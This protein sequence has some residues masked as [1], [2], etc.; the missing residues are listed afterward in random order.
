MIGHLGCPSGVFELQQSIEGGAGVRRGLVWHGEHLIA[1]R[2]RAHLCGPLRDIVIGEPWESESHAA[3]WLP[4]GR[5]SS[6][7]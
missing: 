2:R 3:R 7:P 1:R 4:R 6:A 5:C